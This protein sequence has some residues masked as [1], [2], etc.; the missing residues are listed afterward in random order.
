MDSGRLVD[1][2]PRIPDDVDKIKSWK[3]PDVVDSSQLKAVR[4]PDSVSTGK[5]K[6]F[7]AVIIDEVL[8]SCSRL[9]IG[10]S[11]HGF[12]SVALGSM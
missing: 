5:V 3:I 11:V 9:Q 6:W 10:R 4:L 1:V 2:K 12:L 7:W 8:L